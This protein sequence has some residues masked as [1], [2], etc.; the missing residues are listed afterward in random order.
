MIKLHLNNIKAEKHFSNVEGLIRNRITVVLRRGYAGKGPNRL[1]LNART[2]TFLNDLLIGDHLRDLIMIKP[3]SI[4]GYLAGLRISYPN[5]IVPNSNDNKVL[6][7]IFLAN[8]YDH[9]LFDKWNFIR[10]IELD[11]CPYCNR[12]YI[13]Y[14]SKTSEIKPQIDHFY[15][16][17]KYPF[18]ALSFYNLIPSCQTCNGFGA[19]EEKDCHAEGLINPYLLDHD[20]F[21][22]TYDIVN[23]NFLN[24]L[25]DKASVTVRFRHSIAGHLTVFK[26][27]KLYAQHSDHVLELII[28]SKVAYS[29]QYRKFLHD[30]FTGF[31]FSD[32]EID[33]MVLGNYSQVEEIHK[34][35]L[36]KLYQ[37]IGRQLGLID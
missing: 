2:I 4:T 25:L 34:R 16:K 6:R 21:G 3:D 9:K 37:D 35:P 30:T 11:T 22:F 24:P 36:A 20:N 18:F 31:T 5:F 14:L 17:S 27:D 7:N 10:N 28:K 15:S 23:I 19:K 32:H 12:N 29:G 1:A 26:L 8:G 33:R 13:Y